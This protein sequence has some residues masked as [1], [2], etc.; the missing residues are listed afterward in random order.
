METLVSIV[1]DK[2]WSRQQERERGARSA[3]P[4]STGTAQ[5]PQRPEKPWCKVSE[6]S[7]PLKACQEC[8]KARGRAALALHV[9]PT[10]KQREWAQ[11]PAGR[12]CLGFRKR[13]DKGKQGWERG[14]EWK[15]LWEHLLCLRSIR[16]STQPGHH[17][18]PSFHCSVTAPGPAITPLPLPHV[19]QGTDTGLVL[20]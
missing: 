11:L 16:S 7:S 9:I 14:A 1:R 18:A 8:S 3:W 5:V 19:A 13:G 2:Q 6:S 17:G 10:V 12:R 4:E 20:G 15:S